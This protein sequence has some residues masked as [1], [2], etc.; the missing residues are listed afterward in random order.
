MITFEQARA[1]TYLANSQ[2]W[3]SNGNRGEYYVEPYGFEDRYF[4]LM[5][6][7]AREALAG[8]DFDFMLEGWPLTLV[9]KSSGEICQVDTLAIQGHVDRMMQVG[10]VPAEV[11]DFCLDRPYCSPVFDDGVSN[12]TA[13]RDLQ[14]HVPVS[15]D[16]RILDLGE[17]P[18]F[19]SR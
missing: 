9:A 2:T 3:E 16:L 15:L 11:W 7:G 14:N 19:T 13:V 18:A 1:L 6:D 4:Y 17:V 10:Q 12:P 8:Q 5:V